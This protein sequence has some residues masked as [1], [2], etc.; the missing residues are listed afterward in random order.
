MMMARC[1]GKGPRQEM[2]EAVESRNNKGERRAELFFARDVESGQD[3]AYE[4]LSEE[5][6]TLT[7]PTEPDPCP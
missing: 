6:R 5:H 1:V 3:R 4:S 7:Q 2:G